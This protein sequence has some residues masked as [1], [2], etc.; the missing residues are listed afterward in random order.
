MASNREGKTNYAR[1]LIVRHLETI[2]E[3]ERQGYLAMAI[4][5]RLAEG[6]PDVAGMPYNTFYR[7]FQRRNEYAA[8]YR[9]P[10]IK[11]MDARDCGFCGAPALLVQGD[12][13]MWTIRCSSCGWSL[14]GLYPDQVTAVEDWDHIMMSVSEITAKDKPMASSGGLCPVCECGISETYNYCPHCGQ[15]LTD[16]EVDMT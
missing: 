9:R 5:R 10:P 12:D 16:K 15:R 6:D 13:G 3:M 7:Q 14:G 11:Q 1:A 2:I 4:Y 8:Q